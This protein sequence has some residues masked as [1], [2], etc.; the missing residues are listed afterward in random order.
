M[1]DIKKQF[2]NTAELY[3][4]ELCKMFEFRYGDT[5]WIGDEVGGTLDIGCGR[6]TLT[7]DDMRYI[8]DNKVTLDEVDEWYDYNN[9]VA[10]IKEYLSMINL[11]HWH[12]GCPH[13]D[14]TR[15]DSELMRVRLGE[16]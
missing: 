6:L 12:K 2:E 4:I 3:R 14:A 5:Y 7:Y 11:K 9:S 15:W 13:V 8:V 10:Y 1:V 16:N